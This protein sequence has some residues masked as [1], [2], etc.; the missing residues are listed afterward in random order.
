VEENKAKIL[1]KMGIEKISS[2]SPAS[3]ENASKITMESPK[4]IFSPKKSSTS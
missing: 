4:Y 2:S 1:G 3:F